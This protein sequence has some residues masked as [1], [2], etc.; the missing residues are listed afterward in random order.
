MKPMSIWQ[1]LTTALAVLVVLL[2][3]GCGLALWIEKA[4][5]TANLES[6]DLAEKYERISF[7]LVLMS[8]AVRGSL[9]EIKGESEKKR[10]D[11]ED[12]L[13][14]NLNAIKTQLADRP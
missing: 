11:A 12:D 7:D 5:T 10:R 9:L 1:R 6:R 4:S 2:I 13:M 3:I 8:D 14:S